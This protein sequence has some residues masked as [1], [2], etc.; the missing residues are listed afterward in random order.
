MGST[1][2]PALSRRSFL[3]RLGVGA[4]A[5][6][7]G[8]AFSAAPAR[9]G[10]SGA[11]AII[12]SDRFSRLFRLPPFSEP[13]PALEAALLELGRPGGV[14]DAKDALERGP[15]DLITDPSL[16]LGNRNNPTHTAGTTFVG[17]FLDH[18]M[19]F[20]VGSPLG[21]PTDPQA[22]TNGRTP[23]FDL[24]SVYGGGPVADP[25]LYDSADRAKL[26]VE[27]GGLFEDVPR[28]ADGTAIIADPRN[29]EH[30]VIAGLQAA[31]L[32]FHNNAVDL[33]RESR[34]QQENVFAQARRLTTWHYQ[35]LIVNEFL[36]LFIG[37]P[38]TDDLRSGG[39]RFYRPR[40]G[41][42]SIPVE[43][44]GA[45]YRFGHSMV[46][47]SYRAN[48]A[49]DGGNPFFGL[50]FDP[51]AAGQ[52]DPGDLRGGARAPRR[53]VGWQTFFDFGDG[54][55]KPNKRVDTTISTPLF[56]LPLGAIASG[57]RPT[58]LP[59]RTLLRH[60]T[61]ELP[62]GQTIAQQL[63][64]PA[65]ASADL[66]DLAAFGVGFERSTPLWIYVLR[67]AEVIE[68]GLHLGPVGGR[69]VGEVI[70]GLLEADPGSYLV[71][72]PR[73][74][75]TLGSGGSFGMTDFLT[76]A[77]VDPKSRGQ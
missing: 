70:L 15:I 24:D 17:Q 28:A 10:A 45:A 39:R 6:G 29:D 14:L 22:S 35:W 60:L 26:K 31:F 48:L 38:L 58:A 75:P 20:D 71:D 1:T 36:P 76:F 43:F 56:N 4:A 40:R 32:K 53:F 46:R 64:V 13:S 11:H 51:A 67:E 27:S 72:E 25:Q 47:P 37:Q 42:A 23:S 66:A 12:R 62:S 33:A 50:I 3:A 65:L 2:P 68:D 18:D 59:Q 7:V 52:A 41:E 55:V 5:V 8:G 73:W 21:Q 19:T 44:Q 9:A 49:G 34:S 30:V 77:G 61:W 16:S 69:I 54:Q 63:G 74:R 57:D